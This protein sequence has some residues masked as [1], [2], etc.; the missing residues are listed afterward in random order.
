MFFITF[1]FSSRTNDYYY[2]F[3]LNEWSEEVDKA[4]KQAK[5]PDVCVVGGRFWLLFFFSFAE[6]L[7]WV[8]EGSNI[9]RK[10]FV[11]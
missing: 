2:Y 8:W 3:I 7:V 6:M 9:W 10:C 1:M 5:P 4:I 11:S